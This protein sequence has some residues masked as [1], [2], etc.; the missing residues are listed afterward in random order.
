M[1]RHNNTN[2]KQQRRKYSSYENANDDDNMKKVHQP[3]IGVFGASS[4]T[5]QSF[6]KL[7]LD[8]RYHIQAL[9]V[10]DDHSITEST[11]DHPDLQYVYTNSYYD[12][13]ALESVVYNVDYCVCL[14]HDVDLSETTYHSNSQRSSNNK[15]NKKQSERPISTFLEMLYPILLQ[16]R[17]LKVFLFQV[18]VLSFFCLQLL[19]DHSK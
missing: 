12:K 1:S 5:G 17:H 19:F 18:C 6:V 2:A 7:A 15:A 14:L 13:E 8:A 11:L 3:K 16:Q 9:H 10:S 4:P